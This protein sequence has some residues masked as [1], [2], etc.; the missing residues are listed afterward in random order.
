MKEQQKRSLL[1]KKILIFAIS[2]KI[3]PKKNFIFG[4]LMIKKSFM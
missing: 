4:T 1:L 2:T 3:L